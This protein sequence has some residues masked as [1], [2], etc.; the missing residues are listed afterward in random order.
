MFP[1]NQARNE[2]Y[3]GCLMLDDTSFVK[4]I[5]HVLQSYIGYAIEEIG[6]IDLS[7]TL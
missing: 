2:L 3:M 4:Q 5:S 1:V 6:G 7:H